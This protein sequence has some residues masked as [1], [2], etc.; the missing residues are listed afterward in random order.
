MRARPPELVGE[1]ATGAAASGHVVPVVDPV[2]STPVV[3]PVVATPVVTPPVVATPVVTPVVATPVVKPVRPVVTPVS[4]VVAP[5][6]PPSE[7]LPKPVPPDEQEVPSTTVPPNTK[8]SPAI[9][10]GSFTEILPDGMDRAKDSRQT[11]PRTAI[12]VTWTLR[13]L[14]IEESTPHREPKPPSQAEVSLPAG[15]RT[16]SSLHSES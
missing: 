9:K 1:H 4:P 2:V 7:P 15:S 13:R 3:T 6:E 11:P 12:D 8:T 10:R 5:V 14:S 16:P